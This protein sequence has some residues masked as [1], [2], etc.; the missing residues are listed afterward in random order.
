MHPSF[1]TSWRVCREPR[2]VG[3]LDALVLRQTVER[4]RTADVGGGGGLRPNTK[5]HEIPLRGTRKAG[6]RVVGVRKMGTWKAFMSAGMR[7]RTAR[8][9][10]GRLHSN[11]VAA[12]KG[13][14]GFCVFGGSRLGRG[15][16][17]PQNTQKRP[18]ADTEAH[19]RELGRGI[20]V[21]QFFDCSCLVSVDS[22]A[23]WLR[24]AVFAH[25]RK[26]LNFAIMCGVLRLRFT[27]VFCA[28]E[29]RSSMS[30]T[31]IAI[32]GDESLRSRIYT[33]RGV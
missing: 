33:I 2:E 3:V 4:S 19:R 12:R 1:L 10:E 11:G 22:G 32:I 8:G 7:R 5:P 29:G 14:R 18:S 6:G 16:D 20:V 9:S 31:S 24:G 23:G 15:L 28:L 13:P 21:R 30:E 26:T 27:D 17:L 25:C